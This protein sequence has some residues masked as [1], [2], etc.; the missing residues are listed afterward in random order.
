M[1][2]I[3]TANQFLAQGLAA[4]LP[5]IIDRMQTVIVNNIAAAR[6][7]L[8]RESVDLVI[9]DGSLSAW[10]LTAFFETP[11]ASLPPSL[12]LVETPDQVEI[13]QQ[14]GIAYILKG[15]ESAELVSSLERLLRKS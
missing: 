9:V 10:D 15:E 3:L 12:L 6:Q 2:L 7:I 14:A 8:A 13:A 5:T 4:L 1:V 11:T